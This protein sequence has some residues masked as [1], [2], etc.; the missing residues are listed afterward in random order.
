MSRKPPVDKTLLDKYFNNH[1]T[2]EERQLVLDWLSNPENK[3]L[4]REPMW[5]QWQELEDRGQVPLKAEKLL[6]QIQEKIR[7]GK[8]ANS[9]RSHSFFSWKMVAVWSAILLMCVP[10]MIFLKPAES[11]STTSSLADPQTSSQIV[12]KVTSSSGE[13]I[14]KVLADGTKVWLN[15]QSSVLYPVSFSGQRTREVFLSGEAFFDV[16]EDKE[17]PFIVRT[18][19]IHIK[20]L[21][22]AFNV[23]SYEGDPTVKTTLVRGKVE[24]QSGTGDGEKAVELRPNQ[25]AVFSHSTEK[26]TLLNVEVEK[27]ISWNSGSLTFK[28]ENLYDVVKSLE[29]WYGVAIHIPDETNMDCRL[30]ARIDKESLDQTLQMLQSVTGITYRIEGR[31]VFIN[32]NICEQ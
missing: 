26:M 32:G 24:I 30:T 25:Q 19:D 6:L 10:A 20:V 4:L 15:A 14:L 13:I 5:S 9:R 17:H 27:F 2:E 29:R 31:K 1:C 12:A 3:L 21:G 7:P 16:A 23:K 28:N 22:T 11:E 18:K 8:H